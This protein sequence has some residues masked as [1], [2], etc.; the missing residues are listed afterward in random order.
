[1]LDV[2]FPPF[3]AW[4]RADAAGNVDRVHTKAVRPTVGEAVF[5][6][7]VAP[8]DD[9]PVLVWMRGTIPAWVAAAVEAAGYAGRKID[10]AVWAESG[11]TAFYATCVSLDALTL[12]PTPDGGILCVRLDPPT[13]TLTVDLVPLTPKSDV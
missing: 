8:V 3:V 5:V 13:A 7:V 11:Y 4:A 12:C 1:M 10:R 9:C 2:D 6:S